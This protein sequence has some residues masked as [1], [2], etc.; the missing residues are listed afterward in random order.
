MVGGW[1][2]VPSRAQA[3]GWPWDMKADSEETEKST[4]KKQQGSAPAWQEERRCRCAVPEMGH[5]LHC[6]LA[7][8]RGI[9]MVTSA[10]FLIS[11]TPGR[12]LPCRE[13][14]ASPRCSAFSL[15]KPGRTAVACSGQQGEG[16]CSWRN[17]CSLPLQLHSLTP[18]GTKEPGKRHHDG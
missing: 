4:N 9:F 2:R 14:T 13:I 10:L 15:C 7:A 12:S 11:L 5:N 1:V 6:L 17:R 8:G 3:C 18:A 16:L